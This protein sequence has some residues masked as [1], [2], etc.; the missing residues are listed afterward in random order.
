LVLYGL[1]QAKKSPDHGHPLGYGREI[2]F[3]SFVVAVMVFA[4]GAGVSLYEGITHVLNPTPIQD[5]AVNFAVIGLSALFDGT[6]WWIAVRNFKGPMKFSSLIGAIHNSKDP[7]SF[8]VMFEDSAALI[9]LVIAFAGT[10][11]LVRYDLPII[12]GIASILIG[13]VLAVTAASLAWE[14]K[15]LLIGEAADPVI[16]ASM[17]RVANEMEGVAH[18][19]GIITVHLA[20]DQ[21]LVALSLEFSDDL[22]TPEIELKISELERR[23][24][25]LHPTVIAMFVKPQSS[26]DFKES[27]GRRYASSGRL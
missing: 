21:I 18:A 27:I 3:W 15:G 8:M 24:R 1:H 25:Q 13:L 17:M 26:G 2:Y 11:L 5:T 4:L 6:T 22:R 23:L 20:P 12:D 16:V 9:G 10:C 19:N 14:T 7:P